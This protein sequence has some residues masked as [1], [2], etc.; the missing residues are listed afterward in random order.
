MKLKI[1]ELS[2]IVEDLKDAQQLAE[3]NPKMKGNTKELQKRKQF[4]SEHENLINTVKK[5]LEQRSMGSIDPKRRSDLFGDEP[6]DKYSKFDED[7]VRDNQEYIDQLLVEQEKIKQ[8]QG[9]GLEQV[10]TGVEVLKEK[11]HIIGDTMDEQKKDLEVF[12]GEA[13]RTKG[14][15]QRANAQMNQL[16]KGTDKGKLICIA[17]LIVI[18]VA[19]VVVFFALN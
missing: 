15:L 13:G 11:A 19:M 4:L 18:I 5:S 14:L 16:L 8:Q 17:I 12:D 6:K 10:I 1:T 9:Q 7:V 3:Q 2:E